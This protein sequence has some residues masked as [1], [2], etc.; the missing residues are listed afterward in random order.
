[1]AV[2]VG[3]SWVSEAALAYAKNAVENSNSE[4]SS[5]LS[6]LSEKY[7]D[8]NFMASTTP[9]QGKGT[10]NISISPNI[11]RQMEQDPEKRLE[12]E[13]L[14]YDCVQ[15]QKS[16]AFKDSSVIASGFI[17]NADG[18]LGGWSISRSG[19]EKVR[20]Q[21]KLDK[22]D[23]KSW[24][25]KL[26]EMQKEKKAKRKEEQQK[27]SERAEDKKQETARNTADREGVRVV[28]SE[29]G[30]E[31]A[32]Q[33]E[34]AATS[35]DDSKTFDN[36]KDFWN[37]LAGKYPS[38][39][40]GTVSISGSYLKECMNDEEKRKELFK[41]LDDAEYMVKDAEENV[42]GY[43]GM[44][45]RIDDK[46]NMET[47]TYG[48]K[49]GVNEQKRTRQIAAAKTG[50][51]IQMVM[52]LLQKDL[53]DC[54]AGLR[55]GACDENEVQKVKALIAKAQQKMAEVQGS[56][57]DKDDEGVDVFSMNMLM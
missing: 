15:V 40:N 6:D 38:L 34:A 33:Q 18:S 27:Q 55:S 19:G 44:R 29:Q 49:V 30:M 22:K 26:C 48:S 12:Y 50:S 52:G 35:E 24:A 32:K 5:V 46:G 36:K 57:S 16:G 53:S 37:Y 43:Q 9:F 41:M 10:N 25:E 21:T 45:I 3:N 20:H 28:F 13:A 56:D 1:M 42:E 4:K 8:T 39:R 31:L 51:D 14:I 23:K 47:E 7:K 2:K 54:Q 11:L 17:I